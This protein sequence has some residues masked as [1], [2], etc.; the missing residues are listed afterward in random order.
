MISPDSDAGP[1]VQT[2]FV[3]CFGKAI[4]IPPALRHSSRQKEPPGRVVL[5]SKNDYLKGGRPL[6]SL[7][8]EMTIV[9]QNPTNYAIILLVCVILQFEQ[10]NGV[11]AFKGVRGWNVFFSGQVA[12]DPHALPVSDIPSRETSRP[13]VYFPR[14]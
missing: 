11:A 2:I 6:Y 3:L 5:I 14:G 13:A 9:Y 12:Y 10:A 1:I 7:P 4:Y 8:S